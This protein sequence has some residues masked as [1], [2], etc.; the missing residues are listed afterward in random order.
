MSYTPFVNLMKRCPALKCMA[1]ATEEWKIINNKDDGVSTKTK[2]D[3]IKGLLQQNI[4]N[5][6]KDF[7]KALKK[8]GNLYYTLVENKNSLIV[9]I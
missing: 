7:L 3:L 8:A 9:N 4:V 5:S 6:E 2:I 1:D